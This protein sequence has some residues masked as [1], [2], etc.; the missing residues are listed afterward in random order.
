MFADDTNVF[1]SHKD[2]KTLF[3]TINTELVKV[4]HWFKANKLS[5][6]VRK[7]IISSFTSLQ[8]KM[9]YF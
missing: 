3:H 1:F 6:N 5:L 8:L 4:N 7:L 2:I 9:I